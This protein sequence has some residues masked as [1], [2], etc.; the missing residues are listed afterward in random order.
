MTLRDQTSPKPNN[1]SCFLPIPA[2]Y[3]VLPNGIIGRA[4]VN[5][6]FRYRMEPQDILR[7]LASLARAPSK[8]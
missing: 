8:A 1:K 4:Y 3:I 2:T 5:P 6:D 7:S